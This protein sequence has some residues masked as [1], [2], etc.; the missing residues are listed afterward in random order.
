MSVYSE[1]P[2]D[3]PA[4]RED[5]HSERERDWSSRPAKGGM[6]RWAAVAGGIAVLASAIA[7]GGALRLPGS[8]ASTAAGGSGRGNSTLFY[9][10]VNQVAFPRWP[11]GSIHLD[12]KVGERPVKFIVDP[13]V[14][15]VVLSP[16]DARAAGLA[17]GN[18][19]YSGRLT[20][21]DGDI[22]IAPVNIQQLIMGSLTLFDVPAAVSQDPI[23]SSVLGAT[24]LKRFPSYEL[25]TERLVLHW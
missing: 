19:D 8:S 15:V 25:E 17:A 1:E 9:H 4:A 13:G 11:D 16:E 24:F 14:A 23:P 10:P 6:L 3:T 2:G 5:W 22:R 7:I 12:A 20:I 18:L 21:A